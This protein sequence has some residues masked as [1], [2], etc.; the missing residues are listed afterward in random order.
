[1]IFSETNK[2]LYRDFT[3]S[4]LKTHGIIVY[5]GN[6]KDYIEESFTLQNLNK[7]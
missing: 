5:G 4:K 6:M 2:F 3:L 7:V 1:M